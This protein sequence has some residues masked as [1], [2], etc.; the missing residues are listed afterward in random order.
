MF[1]TNK[2]I[3]T[4]KR[5]IIHSNSPSFHHLPAFAGGRLEKMNRL[6]KFKSLLPKSNIVFYRKPVTVVRGQKQFLYDADGKKYLDMFAGIV[7]VSVGHC[8]PKVNSALKAQLDKLWHTTCIYHTEPVLEYAAA[9]TAKLPEHLSVCFFTN[10]GSE[11]NDLALALARLHTGR[12]DV[13]SMRN[14][15]HGMTQAVMGCT[16]LGTWKQPMPAG[17]GVLKAMNADP[18]A[19]PWG[20]KRCRDSPVDSI[21]RDCACKP[22]QCEAGDKYLTQF[23]ET[24]R[25]DF[26][27]ASGPAGYIVESIQGVGGTTQFPKNFLPAAF[28]AVH[29][30]GGVCIADEVQT[31]FGRLGSDFWGFQ[32]NKTRPDI[33][34]MAKGIGNGFPMGACVTTPEI[35]ASFGKALYFNTYGG[36]PMASVVGKAVLDV[37]EEE[38]LQK[39]CDVVGTHFLKSLVSLKNPKIGDVRGKGLMIGV[40]MVDEDGK[41]LPVQR[42]GDVFEAIKDAGIL[43]GKGGING[44]VLRIKPPMCITKEDA[45]RTVAAI[46]KALKD[47]KP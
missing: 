21:S 41:P 13:L 47:S 9:L 7:T 26:P 3:S 35:A 31:G 19:G 5:G 30:K 38:G 46:D 25:F 11:A 40:E 23:N 12:F 42:S 18:Y 14:G 8:H 22:G 1:S 2:E 45:D 16:N 33:V 20:G 36:N 44:N 39:N 10:S 37:I 43:V 27:A 4:C 6:D 24:L 29:A 17:L 32:A 34:T 28:D 15:Y